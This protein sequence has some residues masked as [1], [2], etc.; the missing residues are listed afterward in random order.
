MKHSYHPYDQI[1]FKKI[2]N[3][4]G[5]KSLLCKVS[6]GGKTYETPSECEVTQDAVLSPMLFSIYMCPFSQ[7]AWSFR[8]G[9]QQYADDIQLY[10][11]VVADWI[12]FLQLGR[13][14]VSHGRMVKAKLT[15]VEFQYDGDFV[16][17]ERRM[18]VGFQLPARTSKA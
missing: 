11:T 16:A 5:I 8:L 13:G 1:F 6:G 18:G 10:L 3:S 9:C 7:L 14:L 17:G 12:P 2:L 15:E 4:I